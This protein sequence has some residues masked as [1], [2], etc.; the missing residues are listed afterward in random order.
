MTAILLVL[1]LATGMVDAVSFL[2]LGHVFTANMTGNIVFLGFA[3]AGAPGLSVE[4]S[5]LALGCFFVGAVAGGRTAVSRAGWTFAVE[6]V[7]LAVSALLAANGNMPGV[8]AA[9]AVAMGLRNAV[10]RKLGVADLTTTVLTLT[11]T[12]LAADSTLAGGENP[13][14][15]RRCLAIAA[16]L[17]GAWA[18]ATLLARSAALALV[19][20]AAVTAG[21]SLA[22][23]VIQR[24]VEGR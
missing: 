22:A 6:A 19:V 7:L 2:A 9:T 4:R 5:L 10:V 20:C 3:L 1:T 21:C 24:K 14:W 12:G 18:G 23:L 8:I 13:R 11:V 16:M 17:G 15:Q